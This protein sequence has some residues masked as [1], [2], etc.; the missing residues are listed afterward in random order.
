M[1][2][3]DP[4]VRQQVWIAVL[5]VTT[6]HP[7]V[8][9][10]SCGGHTA[11]DCTQCS[12]PPSPGSCKG[13]C[14]F[15][16][17]ACR[18]A[19]STV[20]RPP[21][22]ALDQ[23]V[24]PTVAP[25]VAATAP[26]PATQPPLALPNGPGCDAAMEKCFGDYV[27]ASVGRAGPVQCNAFNA[28]FHPCFQRTRPSC[29]AQEAVL[30]DQKYQRTLQHL[31]QVAP[32]CPVGSTP[33]NGFGSSGSGESG[34]SGSLGRSAGGSSAGFNFTSLN[35]GASYILHNSGIGGPDSTSSGLQAKVIQWIV[36]VCILCCCCGAC[37]ALCHCLF[38][39]RKRSR[40]GRLDS[41]AYP[42]Q[43]PAY[44]E[45]FST[46]RTE[47]Y[48]PPPYATNA[49]DGMGASYYAPGGGVTGPTYAGFVPSAA[50]PTTYFGPSAGGPNY[51]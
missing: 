30:H 20:S 39:G 13:D 25:T 11:V 50:M 4:C 19:A 49:Y 42:A 48:G 7:V 37:G 47:S 9:G 10:V 15:A 23:T 3:G 6:A 40:V 22:A 26:P 34:G 1:L 45:S 41:E 12:N 18:Q 31:R 16:N 24:A 38:G 46:Q 43:Y 21:V 2:A 27:M 33:G 28:I 44:G 29:T 51:Y 8:A 17:G 36:I 5:V 35:S 32:A 14:I